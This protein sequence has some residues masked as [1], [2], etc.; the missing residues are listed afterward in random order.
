MPLSMRPLVVNDARLPAR[1]AH[2]TTSAVKV[3]VIFSPRHL[4][5]VECSDIISGTY[6]W[7]SGDDPKE[8]KARLKYWAQAVACTVKLC[9]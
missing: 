3:R 8:V 7:A 5:P 4:P 2:P 6:A 9:S 1:W